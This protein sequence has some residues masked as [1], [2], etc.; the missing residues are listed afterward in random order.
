[1]SENQPSEAEFGALYAQHA[2]SVS[3]VAYRV[4]RDHA[5]AEDVMQDVFIRLWQG[6]GYDP[7]RGS[8]A[9]YLR[10]M[11]HSR[12]L[13]LWRSA[14][15]KERVEEHLHHA[16]AAE[17]GATPQPDEEALRGAVGE[18]VRAAVRRLPADQREA[19]ALAYWGDLTANETAA[20]RGVPLGTMKSRVRLGL[21]KLR[22]DPALAPTA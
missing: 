9:S 10:M 11:A 13:D 19:L 18:T 3:R 22:R 8:L 12:A 16:G 6:S 17:R 14:R 2:R 21:I 15:S 5:L 20:A 4:L 7:A 1:M